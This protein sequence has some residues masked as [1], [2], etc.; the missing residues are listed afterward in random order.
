DHQL[1]AE[2]GQRFSFK[3]RP[4]LP[5]TVVRGSSAEGG[6]SMRARW[7]RIVATICALAALAAAVG[8]PGT[9][10]RR[11]VERSVGIAAPPAVIR[12]IVHATTLPAPA[13][14]VT[15]SRARVAAPR[16]AVRAAV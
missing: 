9:L 13:V 3:I 7:P 4:P 12:T 1:E 6:W 15:R 10:V 16:P 11:K 14:P 5:M 8:L 2:A